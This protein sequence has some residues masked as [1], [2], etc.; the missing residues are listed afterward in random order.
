LAAEA[1][2]MFEDAC[3]VVVVVGATAVG[4]V[5]AAPVVPGVAA[6]TGGEL[7]ANC[8]PVTTVTWAPSVTWLGL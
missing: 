8:V 3:G 6:G 2:E 7:T 4:E 5:L 1:A